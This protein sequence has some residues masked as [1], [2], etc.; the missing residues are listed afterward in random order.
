MNQYK[1][2]SQ[3]EIEGYKKEIQDLKLEVESL[4]R[5]KL[6]KDEA[7]GGVNNNDG[8][9]YQNAQDSTEEEDHRKNQPI[10]Q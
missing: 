5:Q 2:K 4:K 1:K 10:Q 8:S 7:S 9:L 3:A 6:G